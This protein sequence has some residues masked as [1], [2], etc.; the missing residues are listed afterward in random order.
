MT[1]QPAVRESRSVRLRQDEWDMAEAIARISGERGAGFGLRLALT[2]MGNKM[3][4]D[5]KADQLA[6]TLEQ[7]EAERTA[8]GQ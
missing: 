5:G 2:N 4:Q 6:E 8:G 1:T 7:I 3:C